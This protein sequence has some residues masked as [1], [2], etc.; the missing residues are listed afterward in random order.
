MKIHNKRNLNASLLFIAIGALFAV[1]SQ[2]YPMGTANR[3]GPG[4]FPMWL[5]AILLALGGVVLS[6]AFIPRE[7]Q[8]PP[9]PT[10]W[11]GLVLVL[12][13]VVLFAVLLP[14]AGFVVSVFALVGV[15]SLASPESRLKETLVLAAVLAAM[16]VAV[17]GVGL[18]LQFSTWPPALVHVF[19][20][21]SVTKGL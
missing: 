3:M 21:P 20:A 2:D 18:E 5:A 11:R 15:A 17:F 9:E 6:M 1:Y 12:G 10:D 8:A 13:A 14:F 16:G 7:S 19:E 4:Y